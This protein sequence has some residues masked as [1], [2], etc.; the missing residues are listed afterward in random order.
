[1]SCTAYCVASK[2]PDVCIFVRKNRFLALLIL[3]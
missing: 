1:M 3:L 2:T